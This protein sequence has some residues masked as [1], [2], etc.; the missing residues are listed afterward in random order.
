MQDTFTQHDVLTE[1]TRGNGYG[2]L[3]PRMELLETPTEAA[4][5]CRLP[6][7]ICIA[8]AIDMAYIPSPVQTNYSNSSAN[9]STLL[10]IHWRQ[11]QLTP[12]VLELRHCAQPSIG[13]RYGAIYMTHG[14]TI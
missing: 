8:Y 10:F 7:C 13:H 14:S 6:Y 3:A 2:R 12:E 9:A 1:C 4:E 5:L 11:L